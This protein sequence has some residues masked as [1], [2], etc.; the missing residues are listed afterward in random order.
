MD[1][2]NDQKMNELIEEVKKLNEN[3]E[4]RGNFG[5]KLAFAV[6][7]LALAQ[8]AIAL[9]QIAYSLS[10]DGFSWLRLFYAIILLAVIVWIFKKGD[11]MHAEIFPENKPK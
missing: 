5:N 1:E 6:G 3:L 11:I 10:N 2:E 8:F 4:K 9:W 7:I